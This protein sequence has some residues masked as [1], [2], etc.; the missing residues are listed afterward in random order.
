MV[1]HGLDKIQNVDGQRG[2]QVVW[3]PPGPSA[4]LDLVAPRHADCG[5]GPAGCRRVLAPDCG[6]DV[7]D[8]DHRRHLPSAQHGRGGVPAR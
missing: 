5:R 4:V 1:H 6:R 2:R 3:L 7:G 8:D